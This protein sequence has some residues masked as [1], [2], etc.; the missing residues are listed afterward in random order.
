MKVCRPDVFLTTVSYP[1]KGTPYYGDVAP[2]LVRLGEWATSTDR[3]TS[4]RG[5]HS[6]RFYQLADLLLKSEVAGLT[7]EAGDARRQLR[8]AFDE[9][10][11]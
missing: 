4:I 11:A 8:E 3:D 9:V 2:R 6:R 5:R 1:I 7:V 10:E